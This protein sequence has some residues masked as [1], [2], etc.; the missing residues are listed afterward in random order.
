MKRASPGYGV[1][2]FEFCVAYSALDARAA[3]FK[4]AAVKDATRAINLKTH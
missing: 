3:G 4:V 2:A 1:V